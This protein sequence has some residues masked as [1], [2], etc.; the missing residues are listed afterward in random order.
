MAI[1]PTLRQAREAKGMTT[2]EV[3][4]VT[5]MMVQLVEDLEK[6]DF[7]RIAAPIYGRGF[8]KL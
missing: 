4:R 2:S 1:G 5:R 6:D 8:I 3:A 7:G